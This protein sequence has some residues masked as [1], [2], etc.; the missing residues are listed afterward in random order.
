MPPYIEKKHFHVGKNV[1]DV[2]FLWHSD[3]LFQLTY[4]SFGTS[5]VEKT[6][7]LRAYNKIR[8]K[9]SYTYNQP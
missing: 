9:N 3:T 5:V 7:I 4:I 6:L 2:G 1:A 8:N